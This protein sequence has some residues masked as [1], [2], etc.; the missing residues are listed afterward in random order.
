MNGRKE[1]VVVAEDGRDAGKHYLI[2]EWPAA[3]AEEWGW[4]FLFALNRGG[5][6][7]PVEQVMGLGMAAVAYVGFSAIT[8]GNIDPTEMNPLLN[9]LLECVSF[10][11]DP[12]ARDKATGGIIATPI[13]SGD[14][15]EEVKTRLW[16][17]N[18]VIQ[19]HT[20]FSPAAAISKWIAAAKAAMDS[21]SQDIKTSRPLSD[22][23]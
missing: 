18:E 4:R 7:I 14:D 9:E 19:L 15:I 1:T 20:G 8:R 21:A 17:K 23:P 12:A 5:A 11:R 6:D 13:V 22:T 3:R 2:R 10:V 16:L